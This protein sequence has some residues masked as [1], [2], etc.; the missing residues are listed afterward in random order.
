MEKKRLLPDDI[1]YG[2]KKGLVMLFW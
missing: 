2:R 1:L